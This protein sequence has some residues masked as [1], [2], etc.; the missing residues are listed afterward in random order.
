MMIKFGFLIEEPSWKM[1]SD[2]A[3]CAKSHFAC[4]FFVL[5]DYIEGW[6]NDDQKSTKGGQKC[7]I[8]L[9]MHEYL[10]VYEPS[11]KPLSCLNERII[12]N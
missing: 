12:V 7:Y 4:F 1:E 11:N 3:I 2:E 6:E 10:R 5:Y 9:F 8:Y